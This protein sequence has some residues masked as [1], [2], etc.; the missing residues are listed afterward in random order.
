M[1]EEADRRKAMAVREEEMCPHG[2]TCRFGAWGSCRGVYTEKEY[3][4]FRQK[5]KVRALQADIKCEEARSPCSWC[6]RGCC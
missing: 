4:H 1:R 6:M 3:A 5:E 2:T